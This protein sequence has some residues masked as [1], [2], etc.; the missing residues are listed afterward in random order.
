MALFD[1]LKRLAKLPRSSSPFLTLYLNTRWDSEKQREKVRIF[2]KTRI[3]ECLSQN[4]GLDPE[5]R[6]GMEEDTEKV[7]HYARGVV[8]REWDESYRGV[9]VFACSKY[10]VYEVVRSYMPFVEA[11]AC[12]DQPLLR[13][14]AE[15]AH[16]GEPA[17][18][19]SVAGDAGRMVE[20]ELGGVRREFSFADDEFPGRHDQGGW[21][22]ARYQRHVEEHIQRNLR[23]LAEHLIK[24][25]DERRVRRV[26]V[27]GPAA[28]LAPFEAHFP[29]RVQTAVCARIH[30]DPKASPDIIQSEVLAALDDARVH[31][32][33][34]AVDYLLDKGLGMGRAV[35]GPESVA[36]AVASGKVHELYLDADFRDTGWK[37]S[38][39]RGLGVRVPLGCPLCSA[40]VERVDLG[41]EFVRRALAADGKVVTVAGHE[42][43]RGAWG[44][45][46]ML[47][48]S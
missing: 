29:K 36:D 13:Q 41:E 14:A 7:E 2:V 16:A 39:C 40:P 3:K 34:Q 35:T 17:I 24:W 23:R 10:G 45:G 42:G 31:E 11:F 22:Q 12:A 21:S 8:N 19:A 25:A 46:A 32:D 9:A 44:V 47:R 1:D 38:N 30:I 37:C 27:S 20:F 6:Q 43:L 48:Y 28:L 15:H 5:A 18:F 26:V 33:N 4:G